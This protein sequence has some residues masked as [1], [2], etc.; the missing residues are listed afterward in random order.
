MSIAFEADQVGKR[1]S[2]AN[3]IANVEVEACPY[4]SMLEKRERPK[5]VLHQ[6]Q[7]KSYP[8][9]G[10]RGVLDGLDANAFQS[11]PRYLMQGLSQ[12]TWYKPGVSDFAEETE[13]A[14]ISRG[15][16]A[17]QIADAMVTVKRQIEKRCLSAE[18]NALD[19]GSTH[20]N[21]T[22]G[23]FS[24]LQNSAQSY[25]PVPEGFRT[26]TASRYTGTLAAYG[27]ETLLGMGRSA[28][29]QRKGT[30]KLTGLLGIDFKAKHTTFSVRQDNVT[31]TTPVRTFFQ[32][33][34]ENKLIRVIDKL[35]LDTGE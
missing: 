7:V 33:A 30:S 3:L 21:E 34:D 26:P 4:T 35:V 1:Q 14:G 22:R 20:G 28:Y 27:E 12:K 24:Y 18:D 11:N 23:I 16:M 6:W 25:L 31:G 8:V 32:N 5:Q 9:T 17:E 15:E 29:K 10:H 13:V 2:L 19:D